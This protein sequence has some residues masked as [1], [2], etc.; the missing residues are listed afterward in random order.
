MKGGSITQ[1][2]DRFAREHMDRL[3]TTKMVQEWLKEECNKELSAY[4]L[5]RILSRHHFFIVESRGSGGRHFRVAIP[6]LVWLDGLKGVS[7]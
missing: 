2:L 3:V 5:G 4:R 7:R 6:M 1:G